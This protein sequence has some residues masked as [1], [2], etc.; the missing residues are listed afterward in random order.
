LD[1]CPTTAPPRLPGAR[2][3]G[4]LALIALSTLACSGTEE[5]EATYELDECQE[6][7]S[8]LSDNTLI[9][10]DFEASVHEMITCGSLTFT[11][12]RAVVDSA[13]EL[14]TGGGGKPGAFTYEDGTYVVNGEGVV[15]E[16]SLKY[17]NDTPGGAVGDKVPGNIFDAEHFLVGADAV[18]EGADLIVSFTEPG[19]LVA[20]LGR[21]EA[22]ESP[23]RL[24]PA[25]LTA[26]GD[27][28]GRL[29]LKSVIYID[30]VRDN[31]VI[32]YKINNGGETLID[33]LFSNTSAMEMTDDA[34][35]TRDDTSQSLVT[36]RWNIDYGDVHG[37]LD[38]VIEAD[39]V[40]G[41][42]DYHVE[43]A[44]D[45][46]IADPEVTFTCL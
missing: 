18:L 31:A 33:T 11:L 28:F 15:M 36:T 17:T 14:F 5:K 37:A 32:T 30:D 8:D 42:F 21:G 41:E 34:T 35:A 39:V 26:L 24:S 2:L 1:S 20:L 46:L 40:G 9:A 27:T 22:P 3:V 45:P 44:Y 38:G 6:K 23:L 19:P 10:W 12:I 4:V 7:G 43:Y 13:D 16:I 29:R 25:D